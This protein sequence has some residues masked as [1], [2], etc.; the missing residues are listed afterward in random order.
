MLSMAA[1]QIG[2]PIATVILVIPNDRLLH[3]VMIFP[4]EEARWYRRTTI[5]SPPSFLQRFFRSEPMSLFL[6]RPFGPL[7]GRKIR[8]SLF[9]ILIEASYKY[10]VAIKMAKLSEACSAVL[11]I[12]DTRIILPDHIDAPL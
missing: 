6:E 9:L 1:G 3:A 2:N 8:P 10:H 5:R 4:S 12:D 7:N 11:W